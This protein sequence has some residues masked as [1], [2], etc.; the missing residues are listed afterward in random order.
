MVII[1]EH[2]T[3]QQRS[4]GEAKVALKG[5]SRDDPFVCGRFDGAGFGGALVQR[6]SGGGPGA[7]PLGLVRPPRKD[8]AAGITNVSVWLGKPV[9]AHGSVVVKDGHLFGGRKWLR[10]L[11][12]NVAFGANFPGHAE[13]SKVA[14]RMAEFGINGVRFHHMD[15][16]MAPG[17]IFA[18]GGRALDPAQLDKLDFFIAE[19]KKNGIY[20]DPN[21]HVSRTSPDSFQVRGNDQL[22]QRSG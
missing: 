20:T 8:Q 11:G 6:G 14:A 9:G 2:M 22:L 16:H 1:F 21:P 17:G 5:E 10:S 13:A 15:M 3:N 12:V 18:R 19:L 7:A 4:T